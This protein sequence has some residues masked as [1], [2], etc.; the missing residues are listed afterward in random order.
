MMESSALDGIATEDWSN[1]TSVL[2][3]RRTGAL[4]KSPDT[5]MNAAASGGDII[6]SDS[7]IMSSAAFHRVDV[8]R[9]A[10][11]MDQG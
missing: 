7:I 1:G 3:F 5:F 11:E 10:D 2:L 8:H 6:K 9:E 4:S